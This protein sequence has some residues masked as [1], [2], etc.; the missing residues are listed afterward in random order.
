MKNTILEFEQFGS[1]LDVEGEAA[2]CSI[3]EGCDQMPEIHRSR[4]SRPLSHIDAG[5]D[6]V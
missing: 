2:V 5:S 3:P 4:P 1:S 6:A